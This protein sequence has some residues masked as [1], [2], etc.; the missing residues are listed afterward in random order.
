MSTLT[1]LS[2]GQK[3]LWF[4][5]ALAP[6]SGAYN[7]FGVVRI[8]R[9]LDA[10]AIERTF[11]ALVR[12]HAALRSTFQAAD[13]DPRQQ[14]VEGT[15]LD[16]AAEDASAWSAEALAS[17]LR[18][19]AY[20]PF[21]LARGPL[22]RV[23]AFGTGDTTVLLIVMH[24]IVG[25][26]WS[27]GILLRELGAGYPTPEGVAAGL[28]AL[29]RS[30]A[31]W[32]AKE[33]ETVAGP[34]G[35]ALWEYWRER[36][37]GALP[38]LELPV[39]RPRPTAQTYAGANRA[40]GLDAERF[41]ALRALGRAHRT[42]AFATLLAA[43]Q[44]LLHRWTGQEDVLI[45]T[46]VSGRVARE[47]AGPIGYFV[48]PV[49]LRADLSGDP[50]CGDFLRRVGETARDDLA[51]QGYPFPLLTERLRPARDPSR[52]PVFQAMFAHHKVP[53]LSDG[54][55]AGFTLGIEGTRLELPGLSFESMR[56]VHRTAQFDL[57]LLASEGAG[58]RL[59]LACQYNTDLFDATTID[60][61]LARL[62]T[63]LRE[64]TVD[65]RRP[66]SALP[67]LSPAERQQLVSEWNDTGKPG[68]PGE[69][70]LL[71]VGFLRQAARQ[72]EAVALV[73]G[74]RSVRYGELAAQ[75]LRLAGHLR[76]L[77]VGP[78][79]TVGVCLERSVEMVTA[80]LGI[81]VAGG[82]YVPLDPGYPEERRA[83]GGFD[84]RDVIREGRP[85]EEVAA[86]SGAVKRDLISAGENLKC[87]IRT[88]PVM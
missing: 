20:A 40:R 87:G 81:L 15:P 35:E 68:E 71:H 47:W 9:P 18:E 16:F 69:P 43:F 6:E 50:P 42:T 33:A 84:E 29:S 8:L 10:A 32:V 45:G 19:G 88:R 75:A 72:P 41:G 73:C 74:E 26:A 67:L 4:L 61:F 62:Q 55:V 57:T 79:T 66:L 83:F 1:P 3:A 80:L 38:V 14:E 28:P 54:D 34:R 44:L 31:D 86:A 56:F 13:G 39:D 24:H 46:P 23:R 30:Y 60:R 82:A 58:R 7:I 12:R 65:P 64:M 77:G 17:R 63:L 5:H 27:M 70:E 59:W 85:I 2:A 48:N 78:E 49:V 53:I 22:L 21:D 25:D 51:H 36:L 37:R 76:G 11:R 52:S